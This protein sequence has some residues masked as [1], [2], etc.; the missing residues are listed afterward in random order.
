MGTEASR[1][2]ARR[3]QS[4]VRVDAPQ[5][6]RTLGEVGVLAPVGI[7]AGEDRVT[8]ADD[9]LFGVVG[10]QTG[11]DVGFGEEGLEG[12]DLAA[13]DVELA[14]EFGRDLDR[15]GQARISIAVV[16]DDTRI[17]RI[18]GERLG[19]RIL[20]PDAHRRRRRRPLDPQHAVD[21]VDL[22]GDGRRPDR[23]GR[24][25]DSDVWIG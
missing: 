13:G 12:E 4:R 1:S 3:S 8:R 21:D 23:L 11:Q 5:D 25:S 6:D 18:G 9:Q 17:V 22:E 2:A 14:D 7:R 24:A 10:D 15:D 20:E 16:V 19:E